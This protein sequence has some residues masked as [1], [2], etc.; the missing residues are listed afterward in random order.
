MSSIGHRAAAI[1]SAALCALTLLAPAGARAQDSTTVQRVLEGMQLHGFAT[2]SAAKTNGNEFL[3]GTED[4]N[5][6]DQSLAL[7]FSTRLNDHL[8]IHAQVYWESVDGS[9]SAIDYAF[10]EWQF[11][12]TL[13]LR[14]GQVQQPFGLFTEIRDVGTL[15]PF[16]ELPQAVYGPT[17]FTGEAFKGV[18][19]GGTRELGAWA[20]DYDVYGG[21]TETADDE[22]GVSYFE[23]GPDTVGTRAAEEADAIEVTNDV[24][25]G[26]VVL[27]TPIDGF[28]F[29]V[30]AY[31]GKI[32]EEP[33]H[34]ANYGVHASYITDRV[35]VRLEG[36]QENESTGEVSR[37]GYGEAA[38][39]VTPHWQLATTYGAFRMNLKD[40]DISSAPSLMEHRDG[41]VGLNFWMSPSFVFKLSYHDVRGSHFARPAP[42]EL[43]RAIADGTLKERTRMVAFGTQFSF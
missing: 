34:R 41:A 1:A 3:G 11:S 38:F 14:A 32:A 16:L 20:L 23:N 21:A 36:V 12:P 24:Y 26:R 25:G 40:I 27:H 43:A 33:L 30:G 4:G 31:A 18:G 39:M 6:R 28:A 5:W 10:A 35:S 9:P 37:G 17:A 19:L 29:G 8:R 42:E 15:R 22:V 7:N 13:R 2:W